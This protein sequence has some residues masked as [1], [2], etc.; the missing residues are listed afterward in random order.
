MKHYSHHYVN[1]HTLCSRHFFVM[2]GLRSITNG[3]LKNA[4]LVWTSF[5]LP[6]G[7]S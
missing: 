7:S 1:L 2:T 3:T 6:L 4:P 5:T